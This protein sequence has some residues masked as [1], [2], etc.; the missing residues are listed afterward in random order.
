MDVISP[1]SRVSVAFARL[2]RKAV[3]PYI[4]R[5]KPV[6]SGQVGTHLPL[7][8]KPTLRKAMDEHD[9]TPLCVARLNKVEP[10]ATAACNL[11][12]LHHASFN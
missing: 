11:V 6:V 8:C 9:G 4:H 2:I 5:D 3:T 10:Y 1:Q 12:I 7:P